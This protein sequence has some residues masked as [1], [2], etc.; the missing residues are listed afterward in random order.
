[1]GIGRARRSVMIGYKPG[2]A[3]TLIGLFKRSTYKQVR[4]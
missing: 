1:M 4:V 3:S 2:D